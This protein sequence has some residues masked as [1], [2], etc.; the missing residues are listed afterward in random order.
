MFCHKWMKEHFGT[1]KPLPRHFDVELRVPCFE[2]DVT[3][4]NLDVPCHQNDR[5]CHIFMIPAVAG[6]SPS[7]SKGIVLKP[8]GWTYRE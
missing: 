5:D 6:S 8:G 7:C 4:Q 1:H 2:F 3:C